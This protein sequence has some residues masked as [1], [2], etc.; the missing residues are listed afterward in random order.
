ML[1]RPGALPK[2]YF[3][4]RMVQKCLARVP[5]PFL[6][7]V[8]PAVPAAAAAASR[9]SD[10]CFHRPRAAQLWSERKMLAVQRSHRWAGL[11]QPQLAP[12]HAA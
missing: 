5:L 1:W 11:G 6:R 7:G 9:G 4:N 12:M 3:G 2:K 10:L 8:D